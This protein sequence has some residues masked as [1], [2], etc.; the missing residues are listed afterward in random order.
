MI[1]SIVLDY[2]NDLKLDHLVYGINW[3]RFD[4]VNDLVMSDQQL[5]HYCNYMTH[6]ISVLTNVLALSN[7]LRGLFLGFTN[8]SQVGCNWKYMA[9]DI[10]MFTTISLFCIEIYVKHTAFALV[11]STISSLCILGY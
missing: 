7:I 11:S 5:D 10:S 4:S 8:G 9:C 6:D 3:C 2:E 1:V